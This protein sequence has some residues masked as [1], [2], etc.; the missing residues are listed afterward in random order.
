M[1]TDIQV[2]SQCSLG[3]TSIRTSSLTQKF[4]LGE[5]LGGRVEFTTFFL[6]SSF[7]LL[8]VF[9]SLGRNNLIPQVWQIRFIFFCFGYSAFP[10]LMEMPQLFQICQFSSIIIHGQTQSPP[11]KR[12]SSLLVNLGQFYD[13]K[14][15][16]L[17][18]GIKEPARLSNI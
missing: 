9:S 15:D 8:L 16:A 4:V 3:Q 2:A 13:K 17:P 18:L 7:I 10:F 5:N 6:K 11:F 1:H 12:L 14:S